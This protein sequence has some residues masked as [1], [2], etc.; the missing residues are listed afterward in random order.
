MNLLSYKKF[1]MIFY[2]KFLL[3]KVVEISKYRCQIVF[4]DQNKNYHLFY[5]I[6]RPNIQQSFYTYI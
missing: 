5:L 6:Y 4:I 1:K 3:L 2:H